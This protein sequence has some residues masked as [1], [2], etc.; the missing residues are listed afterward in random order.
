MNKL[1]FNALNIYEFILLF[2]CWS[3][4]FFV[5]FFIAFPFDMSHDSNENLSQMLVKRVI[6]SNQTN[7][8]KGKRERKIS[9]FHIYVVVNQLKSK[10]III[11]K[12]NIVHFNCII[13]IESFKIRF[14]VF[15]LFFP[16]PFHHRIHI[17]DLILCFIQKTIPNDSRRLYSSKNRGNETVSFHHHIRHPKSNFQRYF[18]SN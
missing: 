16:P 18:Q 5:E 12:R 1:L 9:I 13:A 11:K 2:Q 17:I 14:D 8:R 6:K 10:E 4:G 7:E 15:G 3:L